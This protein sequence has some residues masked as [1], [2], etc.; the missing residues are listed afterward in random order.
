MRLS[1]LPLSLPLPLPPPKSGTNLGKGGG[2]VREWLKLAELVKDW[3]VAQEE[4]VFARFQ[5][6]SLF[7]N[8]TVPVI[9]P[10]LRP[11]LYVQV[12]LQDIQP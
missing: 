2:H 4:L 6:S 12:T 9:H 8:G 1:A 7:D 5:L 3:T 10:G 11:W